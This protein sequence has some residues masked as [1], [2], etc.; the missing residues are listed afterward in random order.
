LLLHSSHDIAIRHESDDLAHQLDN[1][2]SCCAVV[3][4]NC[5]GDRIESRQP[6]TGSQ[7]DLSIWQ[8]SVNRFVA[9]QVIRRKGE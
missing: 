2:E 1:Y 4:L 7:R 5:L 6:Q 8:P 9:V 3:D